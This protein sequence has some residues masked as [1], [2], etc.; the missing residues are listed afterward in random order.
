MRKS[1]RLCFISP[2]SL[3][4]VHIIQTRRERVIECQRREQLLPEDHHSV[5]ECQASEFGKSCNWSVRY[6]DVYSLSLFFWIVF[7]PVHGK[8]SFLVKTKLLYGVTKGL[9]S[10]W[11]AFWGLRILKSWKWLVLRAATF[12]FGTLSACLSKVVET[13]CTAAFWSLRERRRRKRKTFD[14]RTPGRDLEICSTVDQWVW[15]AKLTLVQE[16][17]WLN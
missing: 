4:Y 1:Q 13:P 16:G 8:T 17:R 10:Y 7:C 11:P 6:A 2:C 9:S 12:G 14:T 15:K 5:G 3:Q